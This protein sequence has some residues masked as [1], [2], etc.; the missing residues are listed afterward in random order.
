MEFDFVLTESHLLEI[1]IS[2]FLFHFE[3][4]KFFS[5]LLSDADGALILLLLSFMIPL[6]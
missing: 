5:Q 2:L 6:P 1:Y 4:L 3:K